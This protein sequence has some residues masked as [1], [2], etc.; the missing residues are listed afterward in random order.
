MLARAATQCL[1]QLRYGMCVRSCS[2][3]VQPM[4][5][6]SF[7]FVPLF[8]LCSPPTASLYD[9]GSPHP[10]H[11]QQLDKHSTNL[12]F[13]GELQSDSHESSNKVLEEVR[14][15]AGVCKI[16]E[17]VQQ[18]VFPSRLGTLS[19]FSDQDRGSNQG[20]PCVS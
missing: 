8:L 15:H 10:S 4:S 2:S 18:R 20:R 17:I 13:H 9:P 19:G 1:H 16:Q 3:L 14:I 11:P 5:V 12:Y 6:S 7:F